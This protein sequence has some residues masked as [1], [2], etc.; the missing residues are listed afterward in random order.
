MTT[1]A[2]LVSGDNT[3][4][5]VT[6]AHLQAAFTAMRWYGWGYTAAMRD[7]VLR[8]LVECR[9]AIMRTAEWERTTK[10]TVVPVKRVRLGADGHPMG[11]C[12]QMAPGPR[13]VPAEPD[14]FIDQPQ[15]QGIT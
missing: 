5:P 11:W 14:L 9:A 3:P 8:R 7:P 4:P 15:P 13:V 6:E 2:H 12:T 10:R 1:R